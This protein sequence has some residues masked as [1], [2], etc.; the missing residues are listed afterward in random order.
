MVLQSPGSSAAR[1][2]DVTSREGRPSPRSRHV[3]EAK[4]R[5][6]ADLGVQK[7]GK[8]KWKGGCSGECRAR[9]RAGG[10]GP[11]LPVPTRYGRR[12]RRLRPPHSQQS[13][14]TSKLPRSVVNNQAACRRGTFSFPMT[15]GPWILNGSVTMRPLLTSF[16]PSQGEGTCGLTKLPEIGHSEGNCKGPSQRGHCSCRLYCPDPPPCHSLVLKLLGTLLL[17]DFKFTLWL[18]RERYF[19]V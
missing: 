15:A 5:G 14:A 1:R 12:L 7:T 10:E 9:A 13:P 11:R 6:P 18:R 4:P 3:R 8:G 16:T 19:L 17:V 2:D